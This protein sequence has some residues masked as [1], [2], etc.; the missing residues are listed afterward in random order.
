VFSISKR[1]VIAGEGSFRLIVFSNVPPLS[2]FHMLLAPRG[3]EYLICSCSLWGLP[4]LV[5]VFC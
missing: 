3:F 5:I 4:S 2:L 1:V